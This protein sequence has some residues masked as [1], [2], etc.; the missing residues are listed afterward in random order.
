M[1]ELSKQQL[2]AMEK[3]K[4][5]Y[6]QFVTEFKVLADSEADEFKIKETINILQDK[7]PNNKKQFML[8]GYAGTGKTTLVNFLIKELGLS[9]GEVLFMAPTGK[10]SLVLRSKGIPAKT[11]HSAIYTVIEDS[12]L[13]EMTNEEVEEYYKKK[14]LGIN[15]VLKPD[16]GSVYSLII[17]DETSMVSNEILE[18]IQCFGVPTIYLG[19]D[20]QLEPVNGSNDIIKKPDFQL[21]EIHRQALDN[22]I[23]QASIMIR[24]G[25]SLPFGAIGKDFFRISRRELERSK[26]FENVLLS[27]DQIICGKNDTRR[28]LNTLVRFYL[29]FVDDSNTDNLLDEEKLPKINEK[30]IIT[31]NNNDVSDIYKTSTLI[32]GMIV[33]IIKE[34][35]LEKLYGFLY[36]TFQDEEGNI[37][38]DVECNASVF[39]PELANTV[40]Y[41]KLMSYTQIDFGYVITCHKSQGSQWEK[42]VVFEE[43]F[44]PSSSRK[45]WLY[46]AV[47]RAIKKCIM[48]TN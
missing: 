33:K 20:E 28:D 24:Q 46:T 45:K 30:M 7:K 21:T 38:E 37:Y 41:K 5:W 17:V 18:H 43:P 27:A 10:A 42:I 34:P 40:F 12:K 6:L 8:L 29:N 1:I 14:N 48:I 23:I 44:G 9:N 15:F 35:R 26:K 11:I 13:S 22:S 2:E 25:K 36:L 19:D 39:Y 31:R 4:K 32:N 16:L 47:T 3:C